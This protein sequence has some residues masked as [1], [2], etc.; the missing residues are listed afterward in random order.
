MK[1]SK[2]LPIKLRPRDSQKT[3]SFIITRAMGTKFRLS[4]QFMKL[5]IDKVKRPKLSLE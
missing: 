1:L 4:Y 3:L 5:P 2:I